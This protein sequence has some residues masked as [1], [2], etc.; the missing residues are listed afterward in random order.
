MNHIVDN[1]LESHP[2][3]VFGGIDFR[4]SIRFQFPDFFRDNDAAAAAENHDVGRAA[5]FKQIDGIFKKFNVAAL[6]AGD[7]DPLSIFFN[8]RVTTSWTE[9]L[10]PRWMT[11]APLDCRILRKML[12]DASWPSNSDVAVMILTLFVGL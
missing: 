4:Y 6:I 9:R 2:G 10:C 3:A 1:S 5:F 11:S 12:M 7:G 8:G